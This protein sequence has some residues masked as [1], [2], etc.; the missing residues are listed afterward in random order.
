MLHNLPC[1]INVIVPKGN[2]IFNDLM[3]GKYSA[4]NPLAGQHITECDYRLLCTLYKDASTSV[5]PKPIMMKSC[6]LYVNL[7]D[8]EES[9]IVSVSNAQLSL[10]NQ[11]FDKVKQCFFL[12]RVPFQYV[13][14]FSICSQFFF[15]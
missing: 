6:E 12:V 5:I 7:S 15:L 10:Q 14:T 3:G 4:V 2:F 11:W 8:A 13:R 9:L 1:I